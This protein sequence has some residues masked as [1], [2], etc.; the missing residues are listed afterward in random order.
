MYSYLYVCAHTYNVHYICTV[1]RP[2]E[3][4]ESPGIRVY[5]L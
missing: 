5:R 1:L 4:I 3:G 2:E